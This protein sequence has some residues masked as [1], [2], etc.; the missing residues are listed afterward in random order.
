MAVGDSVMLG[1]EMRT[2]EGGRM[3][4]P[5]VMA[6]DGEGQGVVVGN[7]FNCQ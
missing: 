4:L 5:L 3:Q 2:Q 7:Y 6:V 1:Q